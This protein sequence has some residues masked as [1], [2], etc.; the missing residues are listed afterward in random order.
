MRGRVGEPPITPDLIL[1]LGWAAGRTLATVRR[2][3]RRAP[4]RADR[5]GHAHLRLPA[6]SRARSG[7]V[8]GGRR[9]LPVRT[10]ADAGHRLP[11][12]RAAAVGGHRH[13][14]VAQ[15]VRRQRHQ[16]LLRRRR[17]A[18]RRRR[19]R[20][21]A[22][23]GEAAR[24]RAVGG[25]RQGVS[26]RR[27]RGRYIE[28]CKS[29]FP[30]ELDLR[31]LQHRRRLRARRRLPRRAAGVPRAR[32]RCDR[33]SATRPTASNINAGVG[34]THPAVPRGA[35]ARARR[36]SRHR[37]R[38]RRRP[39]GDGRQRRHDSTTATSCSTSSRATTS[40]AAR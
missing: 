38:R 31:G 18:A 22:R 21:R 24:V 39:A 6:R 40:G 10:A 34:A 16:V 7:P 1:K 33:R 15:S 26:R 9:R 37:A 30:T 5:Q 8:G 17:Q 4:A 20:D 27:R 28:F 2:R 23:D 29:T 3:A 12:A 11:D 13:Q 36:R 14:R 32:R 25:A 19:A 35:G